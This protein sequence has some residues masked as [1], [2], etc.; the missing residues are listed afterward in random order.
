MFKIK[1]FHQANRAILLLRIIT[2]LLFFL[3]AFVRVVKYTIPD[4]AE[5]LRDKGFIYPEL[6]VWAITVFELAGSI[7]LAMGYFTRLVSAGFILLLIMG[8]ILIHAQLGWFVG[9]HGTGGSE[10]SVLLIAAL[11]VIAADDKRN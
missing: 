11:L 8:I 7:L 3:H 9:E 4:F 6:V 1:S 5:Y 2:A 10:Y